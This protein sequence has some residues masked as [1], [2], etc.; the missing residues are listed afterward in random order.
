MRMEILSKS[1]STS[2]PEKGN[3]QS[4]FACI[5]AV[6]PTTPVLCLETR[7]FHSGDRCPATDFRQ[8]IPL[9]ISRIFPYSTSLEE[10]EL[11]PSRKNVA[12]H[13]SMAVSNP[14]PPSTRNVCSSSTATSKGHMLQ[15]PTRGSSSSDCK[16]NI[17]TTGVD[18]IRK[19]YLRREFQKQLSNLLQ[20]QD[21]KVQSQITILAG[22]INNRLMHLDVM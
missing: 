22:L 15:N 14:V 12:C 16:Q 10:S 17:T 5:T 13:I 3:A 2:L 20:V 9:Y 7:P 11:R 4:R 8:S 6:S 19:D 18:H 1:V 21:E